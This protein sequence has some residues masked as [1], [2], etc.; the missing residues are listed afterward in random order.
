MFR[1]K[2]IL[3]FE[4]YGDIKIQEINF[5]S[6]KQIF[7]EIKKKIYKQGEKINFNL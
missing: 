4:T 6:K 1:W 3:K 2:F 7:N 5:N